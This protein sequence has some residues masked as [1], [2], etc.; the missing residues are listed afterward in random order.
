M[1]RTKAGD[2]IG[3]HVIDLDGDELIT[4][5]ELAKKWRCTR[6][7]LAR[8]DRLPDGLPYIMIAGRKYRSQKRSREWLARQMQHPNPRRDR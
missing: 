4:D 8:Y 1:L 7:T 5:A 6:R 2:L 3:T